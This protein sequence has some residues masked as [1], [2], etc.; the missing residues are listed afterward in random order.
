MI[1]LNRSEQLVFILVYV[2]KTHTDKDKLDLHSMTDKEI[3]RIYNEIIED[4]K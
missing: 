4:N 1:K 2:D 3:D